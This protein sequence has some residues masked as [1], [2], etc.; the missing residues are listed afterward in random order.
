MRRIVGLMAV[1]ALAV[2]SDWV[3][4]YDGGYGSDQAAAIVLSPGGIPCITGTVTGSDGSEDAVV[5]KYS[6]A[7]GETTATGIADALRQARE[8]SAGTKPV[9]V[10]GSSYL[11]G[12][13]L[14][15]LDAEGQSQSRKL[16][17]ER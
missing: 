10:A 14:A 7:D 3:S 1:F 13:A 8:L 2:G 17:V 9:V 12:E 16:V 15:R 6:P 11:A 4:R 5:I